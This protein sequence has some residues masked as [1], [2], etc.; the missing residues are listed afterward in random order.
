MRQTTLIF[1]ITILPVASDH[2][3]QGRDRE[4]GNG[5]GYGDVSLGEA[6]HNHGSESAVCGGCVNAQLG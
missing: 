3:A 5:G 6:D 1:V 2:P 4:Q